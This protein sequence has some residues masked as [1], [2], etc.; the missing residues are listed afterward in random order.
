MRVVAIDGP[1]GSGKSTT[2]RGVAD[3]LGLHTLDTGAMYRA[4]ALAALDAGVDVSDPEQVAT[5]ARRARMELGDGTVQLDGRDVSAEIRGPEVTGA[6]SAVSAHPAVR[7]VLVERQREWVR[8]RGGGVVEGRDIGTVVFP[9]A[10]VKVF[11]VAADDV[12]AARR[13]RD[14]EAASRDVAVDDVREALTERDRADSS[15]GRALRPEDAAPD[16]M[17]IDTTA[18]TVDDVVARIVARARALDGEMDT[19]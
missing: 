16:A 19:A 17:V 4:V 2:A 8:Q 14:E 9:D 12:R 11:L 10:T 7:T 5:L 1:A 3:A 13:R 6:V 18:S 15:L